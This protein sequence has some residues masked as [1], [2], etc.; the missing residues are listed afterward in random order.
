MGSSRTVRGGGAIVGVRGRGDAGTTS[1]TR[2]TAVVAFGCGEVDTIGTLGE[3]AAA[4]WTAAGTEGGLATSGGGTEPACLGVSVC[5]GAG[6][7]VG[8]RRATTSGG[9][10]AAAFSGTEAGIAGLVAIAVGADGVTGLTAPADAG[11]VDL[12]ATAAGGVAG[13]GVTMVGG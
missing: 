7:G 3:F 12:V 1:G 9:G 11:A 10:I 6:G 2:R 8:G 4:A 5:G 13:C